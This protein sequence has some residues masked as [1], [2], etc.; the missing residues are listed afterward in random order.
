MSISTSGLET[1]KGVGRIPGLTL[2]ALGVVFGDIGTSPLYAI[3]ET[4]GSQHALP[5][6]KPHVL[7]ALSLVFWSIMCVVSFKYV[8]VVMRADNRGEGGSLALL[9]SV[10]RLLGDSGKG[11]VVVALGLFAAGLFYGDSLI[12]PAISI[13][14]AIEGLDV[15]KPGFSHYILPLTLLILTG[16]FAIQRYGTATVGTLFGPIVAIWFATLAFSGIKN[17]GLNPGVLF[18]LSPHHALLF[19]LNNGLNGFLSLGAIVLV[20]TGAEALYADMGHFGRLPIALAWYGFAL[21]SLLLN[22]FGQGAL[23]LTHPEAI[24]NPFFLMVPDWATL[25]LVILAA[26]ATVIAS[27]ATISGAFSITRQAIQ[28]GYLPRLRII[29]TSQHESGQIYMPFV[30]WTL[31]VMIAALVIGFGSSSRL[32]AA[33]GIAVTGTMAVTAILVGIVMLKAWKWRKRYAY[34]LIGLFLVIDLGFFL[35]NIVKIEQGGWFPLA[36]GL[37]CFVLFTTWKRGRDVHLSRIQT[38]AMPIEGFLEHLSEKL[39]RVPGTAI[40]LHGSEQGAPL[41]LMHNIKH[42]KVLHERVVVL[43][44]KTA[45]VPVVSQEQ[46]IEA[47]ALDHGFHQITLNFGFMQDPDIPKALALARGDQLGFF[48]EPLSISYF[49][50]RETIVPQGKSDL[51]PWQAY[52]YASLSRMAAS[53]MDFFHLPVNR[54]VELGGQVEI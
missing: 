36:V 54:V 27:Q 15:A 25:P 53:A 42:N 1:A 11:A 8:L 47:R 40:F 32:A 45:D 48:Y 5:I 13:L 39:A 52:A 28:L 30:N 51:P 2:A 20:V 24:E 19:L 3:K 26:M 14:S 37:G 18:A 31:M 38:D 6:D 21:P 43:T 34:S 35:A 46:R 12:T 22:Y 4:F 7:G 50:S 44:V 33:Y 17:I 9:A 29:H 49:L 41:A 23:L 10:M 16:L